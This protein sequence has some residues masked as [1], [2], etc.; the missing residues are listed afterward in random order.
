LSAENS[1][2]SDRFLAGLVANYGAQFLMLSIG[3][4]ITPRLVGLLGAPIYGKWLVLGQGLTWLG[5]LDLGVMAILPRDVAAAKSIA[6]VNKTIRVTLWIVAM[7]LPVLIVAVAFGVWW[8][9]RNDP[10]VLSAAFVVATGFVVT[11]PFRVVSGL[12]QGLQDLAFLA[13]VQF[14][15]WLTMTLGSLCLAIWDQGINSLA[16]AWVAS[17]TLASLAFLLR[18]RLRYA[19]HRPRTVAWPG[20]RQITSRLQTSGWSSLRQVAQLLMNGA[21]LIVLGAVAGP[22][23]VVAYSCTAKLYSLGMNYPYSIA[24]I[25]S[26]ALS[27]AIHRGR[28][29]QVRI[30]GSI[31]LL[32]M[33]FSGMIGLVIL[34]ANEAFVNLWMG[35]KFYSGPG[36]TFGLVATMMT[37]HYLFTLGQIL[38]SRGQADRALGVAAFLDG[39][40]TVTWIVLMTHWLGPTG[41]PWGNLL[42]VLTTT[43]PIFAY[44]LHRDAAN[45]QPTD[46]T[47]IQI[48]ALSWFGVAAPTIWANAV[49][50]TASLPSALMVGL[51]C[52]LA[53]CYFL[54]RQ[55]NQPPLD[56]YASRILGRFGIGG[57]KRIAE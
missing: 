13:T 7:Q 8:A 21:D 28:D 39:I 36:A 1:T 41:V 12:L 19:R 4:W 35:A 42:G 11:F 48:W 40:A 38:F 17:Q 56:Q 15:S 45:G 32:I 53:Y 57:A 3:I 37:R 16:W 46:Y 9:S 27:E 5:L 50:W 10:S 24:V 54:W 14:C 47:R 18:W 44:C 31:S 33:L 51:P 29:A 26:P 49:G 25:A 23:A 30:A 52:A 43:L 22:E 6:G 34:A 55:V 2:R 20:W